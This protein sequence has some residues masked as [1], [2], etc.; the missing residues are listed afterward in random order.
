MNRHFEKILT[1]MGVK[2]DKD[3]IL[4]TTYL[5]K[6]D[7]EE[8]IMY[9]W[10]LALKTAADNVDVDYNILDNHDPITGENI[11]VYVLKN[12]ILNLTPDDI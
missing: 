12:S 9:V 4:E 10:E 5:S 2:F 8:I 6:S 7:F 1:G 11:E 3:G